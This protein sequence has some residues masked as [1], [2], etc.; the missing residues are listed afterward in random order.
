MTKVTDEMI[1]KIDDALTKGGVSAMVYRDNL[2]DDVVK[3]RIDWGDWKH[4]H[5]KARYIVNGVLDGEIR[6]WDEILIEEDG[7]DCYSA[8][9]VVWVGKP[10]EIVLKEV[11][12]A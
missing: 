10:I 1:R 11:K 7:S 4:D 2:L 8:V 3:I 12:V 5:W 9:H 6:N